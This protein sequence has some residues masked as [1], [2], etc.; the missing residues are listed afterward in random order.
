VEKQSWPAQTSLQIDQDLHPE[1]RTFAPVVSP[2]LRSTYQ[3]AQRHTITRFNWLLLFQTGSA[4]CPDSH[5]SIGPRLLERFYFARLYC[6]S[7][8]ETPLP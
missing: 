1:H 5:S 4:P 3:S 8:Q 2:A 7:I 6:V